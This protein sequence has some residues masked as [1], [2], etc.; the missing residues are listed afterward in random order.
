MQAY[1]VEQIR[2]LI[3]DS[4]LHE[5]SVRDSSN[6]LVA[7]SSLSIDDPAE[8]LRQFDYY[9]ENFLS[10]G[11]YTIKVRRFGAAHNTA[12]TKKMLVGNGSF[13]TPQNNF[14]PMASP[15]NEA[16]LREKIKLEIKN[17]MRLEAIEKK[18]ERLYDLVGDVLEVLEKLTDGEP[19]NDTKENG[20][21]K[22]LKDTLQ[23]GIETT[24]NEQMKD[25]ATS[26]G[27]KKSLFS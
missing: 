24:V 2:N 10:D 25:F 9:L 6:D 15:Q 27:S 12:I 8:S 26:F 20:I 16:D 21:V 17:E 14:A 13:K 19:E 4:K 11:V 22:G 3:T 5:W 7:S 1:N 23:K 18:V